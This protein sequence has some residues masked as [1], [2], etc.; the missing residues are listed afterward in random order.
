MKLD[1]LERLPRPGQRQLALGRAVGV[2]ERS[3][4]G[5]AFGDD[6]QII[7]RQRLVE[8]AFA[9]IQLGLLELHQL[10]KLRRFGELTPDVA[11]RLLP[12]FR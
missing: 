12:T 9:T 8:P 1:V 6:A 4:R 10:E 2:V 7:D 5:S 11:H 3:L